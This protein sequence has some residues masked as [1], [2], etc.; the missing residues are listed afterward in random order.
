MVHQL[1]GLGLE[2][3]ELGGSWGEEEKDFWRKAAERALAVEHYREVAER[4]EAK[5]WGWEALYDK[6]TERPWKAE[7]QE[8]VLKERI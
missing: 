6:M 2:E 5:Q 3:G 7:K 4:A 8:G 1:K